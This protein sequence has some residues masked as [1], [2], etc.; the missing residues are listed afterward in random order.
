MQIGVL[1]SYLRPWL[2]SESVLSECY[3]SKQKKIDS[4]IRKAGSSLIFTADDERRV[5][6]VY[7]E[8][9]QKAARKLLKNEKVEFTALGLFR[10]YYMKNHILSANPVK[11]FKACALLAAKI[12]NLAF[13]Q[14]STFHQLL[15]KIDISKQEY[16]RYELKLLEG[17]DFSISFFEIPQLFWFLVKKLTLSSVEAVNDSEMMSFLRKLVRTDYYYTENPAILVLVSIHRF[18]RKSPEDLLTFFDI[19]HEAVIKRL[20]HF[21]NLRDQDIF[22]SEALLTE[23][24][25]KFDRLNKLTLNQAPPIKN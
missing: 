17:I 5:I 11:L 23:A 4:L 19:A 13:E 22:P 16:V 8:S 20:K 10:R 21:E 18:S 9:A 2:V 6:F 7:S 14:D 25:E 24:K 3:I 1:P 12:E 15:E